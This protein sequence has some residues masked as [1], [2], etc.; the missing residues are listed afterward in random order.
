M[1]SV[2]REGAGY[3]GEVSIC[4]SLQNLMAASRRRRM[5]SNTGQRPPARPFVT[6]AKLV[7]VG[8]TQVATPEG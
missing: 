8:V 4:R 3:D 7:E 5:D 2:P 1:A 6:R